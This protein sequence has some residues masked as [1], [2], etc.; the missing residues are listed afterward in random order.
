MQRF[1]AESI[2]RKTPAKLRLET[3][4]CIRISANLLRS[5]GD[6]PVFFG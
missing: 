4:I 5:A 2:I 6:F 3:Y 1:G